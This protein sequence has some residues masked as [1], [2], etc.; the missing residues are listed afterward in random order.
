MSDGSLDRAFIS[1]SGMI[2]AGKSTLA[3]ALANA[4]GLDVYFEPVDDNVYLEDFYRDMSRHSFPMQIWLLNK[5]FN[6]Q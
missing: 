1:I 2:G 4:L 3:A 5:R 6:Q